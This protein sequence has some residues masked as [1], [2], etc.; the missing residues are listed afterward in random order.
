MAFPDSS[1][2]LDKFQS[3]MKCM[4][5]NISVI[6]AGMC[7]VTQSQITSCPS[8]KEF[9]TFHFCDLCQKSSGTEVTSESP[10]L[11]F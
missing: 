6:C 4:G 2:V 1:S 10:F 9:D 5:R 8:K 11:I 3:A 7:C